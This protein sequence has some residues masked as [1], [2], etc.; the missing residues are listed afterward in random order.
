MLGKINHYLNLTATRS[1]NLALLLL[2]LILAYGFFGPAMMKWQDMEAVG[3]WFHSLGYPFPH[4]NAYLSGTT[5]LL[6]V[7][8]LVLGFGIR[9]ISVALIF[10]MFVAI[11]TVH[12]RHG[13][14]TGNNGFEIP[15]YYGLML[16]AL[17][18]FGGGKY[19]LD[20]FLRKK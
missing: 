10:V 18:A 6:G 15:L 20:Y 12:L 16:F 9:Y 19:S 2:R 7:I 3:N 11:T 5:E 4:L 13:F 14:E 17:F 1:Q 8:L